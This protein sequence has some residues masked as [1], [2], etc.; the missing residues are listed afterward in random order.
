[1]DLLSDPAHRG[2][3][4]HPILREFVAR[5]DGHCHR[6]SHLVIADLLIPAEV[7]AF[8]DAVV[9]DLLAVV[10]SQLQERP[11]LV[12]AEFT[13]GRGIAQ[14]IH[15]WQSVPV[16]ELLLDAGADINACT[17]V[18]SGETPLATQVRF[19]TING[20]R[21]LL[22]RGADPNRGSRM[23]MPSTTMREMITLL[24]E[25]GWDIQRGSEILH[26]ANHGHGSRVRIWLEYGVDPNTRDEQG[27]T[28]LH[29]LAARGTGREAIRALVDAGADVHQKDAHGHTP[30]DLARSAKRKTAAEVLTAVARSL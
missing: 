19:G 13:A 4:A 3:Q 16:G 18:H 14:A 23:F 10:R 26:D 7:R 29:L 11:E 24:I 8:R 9:A 15:H 25:H 30:L 20:V 6:Q 21:M 12:H 1:M 27:R 17:T 5:N 22:E 2:Y 28:A